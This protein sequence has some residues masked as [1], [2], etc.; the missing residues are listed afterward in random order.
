MSVLFLLFQTLSFISLT[1]LILLVETFNATLN[2]SGDS[3]HPCLVPDIKGEVFNVSLLGM[4]SI[5]GFFLD[6]LDQDEEDS[7]YS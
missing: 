5:G 2:K 6:S 4:M 3:R 1:L 7:F